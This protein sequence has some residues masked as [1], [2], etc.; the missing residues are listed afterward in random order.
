[1]TDRPRANIARLEHEYLGRGP[2]GPSG[3]RFLSVSPVADFRSTDPSDYA[4]MPFGDS[5]QCK[6]YQL[7]VHCR[8]R[9]LERIGCKQHSHCLDTDML[10]TLTNYGSAYQGPTG[11]ESG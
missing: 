1:M 6:L 5:Q 10:S 4:A 8:S 7:G 2:A 9:F 3:G 11:I